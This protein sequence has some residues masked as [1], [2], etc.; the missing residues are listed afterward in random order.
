[1]NNKLRKLNVMQGSEELWLE[2]SI[3]EREPIDTP[4]LITHAIVDLI[5]AMHL[6]S[7][8]CLP[9]QF[10]EMLLVAVARHYAVDFGGEEPASV[11]TLL[12]DLI[13]HLKGFGLLQTVVDYKAENAAENEHLLN[14]FANLLSMERG[15]S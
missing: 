4:D 6:R 3:D 8:T 14:H 1:M 2:L 13:A 15:G 7:V 9:H 10:Y 11:E 5:E 12:L